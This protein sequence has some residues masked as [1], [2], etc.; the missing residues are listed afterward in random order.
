MKVRTA[1]YV[2]REVRTALLWQDCG[3]GTCAEIFSLWDRLLGLDGSP[4]PPCDERRL[5]ETAMI[6]TLH[7]LRADE[8]L[9]RFPRFEDNRA[10]NRLRA[11][12]TVA[13]AAFADDPFPAA[14]FLA[15]RP[16]ARELLNR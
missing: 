15:E 1:F 13:G 6:S 16:S 11:R 3:S 12:I 4:K 14:Y 10:T 9:A 2:L 5:N 8:F 7:P